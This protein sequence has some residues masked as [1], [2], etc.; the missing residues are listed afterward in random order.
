MVKHP[1]DVLGARDV[2]LDNAPFG[3]ARPDLRQGLICSLSLR[4]IV[5]R[6]VDAPLGKLQ[7]RGVASGFWSNAGGESFAAPPGT[8]STSTPLQSKM[9]IQ[10]WLGG[11]RF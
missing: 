4:V 8:E 7:G 3:P 11:F 10:R 5:N 1:L 2:G 9:I 6:D